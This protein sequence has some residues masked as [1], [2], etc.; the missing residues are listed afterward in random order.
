M[1]K[2]SVYIYTHTQIQENW[3]KTSMHPFAAP[4]L[5]LCPKI[6]DL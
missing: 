6:V 2:Y 3:S 5:F 1:L 4:H